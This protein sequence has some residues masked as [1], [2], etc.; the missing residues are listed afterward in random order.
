MDYQLSQMKS[1]TK[2]RRPSH[3]NSSSDEQQMEEDEE[4]EDRTDL[5]ETE[6]LPFRETGSLNIEDD[7]IDLR[8][9]GGRRNKITVETRIDETNVGMRMLRLMG[10]SEGTGLG[11]RRDGRLDPVPISEKRGSDL[12]GIG[13]MS[14][15][16][17]VIDDSTSHRKE[18]ESERM[19]KET[20]EDRRAREEMVAKRTAIKEETLAA[21]QNF[22]CELCEKQYKLHSEFDNHMNSYDHHHKKRMKEMLSSQKLSHSNQAAAQKRREKERKREEKELK[23]LVNGAGGSNLGSAGIGPPVT[24]KTVEGTGGGGWKKTFSSS[25]S[26]TSSKVTSGGW[27]TVEVE[28]GKMENPSLTSVKEENKSVGA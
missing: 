5:L 26:S 13:K 9:D 18:L 11:A 23:R 4:G 7:L 12:T 10:W 27:K 17:K 20:E 8:G 22:R 6:P 25:S 3:G 24:T 15:D 19:L 2:R 1:V 28:R 16:S 21:I 14:L